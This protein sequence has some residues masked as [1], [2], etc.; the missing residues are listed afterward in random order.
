MTK[1]VYCVSVRTFSIVWFTQ[2]NRCSGTILP[3]LAPSLPFWE[4]VCVCCCCFCFWFVVCFIYY[5]LL[6]YFFFHFQIGEAKVLLI[7]FSTYNFLVGDV[8]TCVVHLRYYIF[9]HDRCCWYLNL[10]RK[11]T[12][13]LIKWCD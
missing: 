3:K 13:I 10:I 12:K 8:C 5:L 7:S 1:I 6:L 2:W 9:E 11:E 4:S